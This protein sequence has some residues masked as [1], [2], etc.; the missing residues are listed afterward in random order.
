MNHTKWIGTG[1]LLGLVAFYALSVWQAALRPA[2]IAHAVALGILAVCGAA[3]LAP[4]WIAPSRAPRANKIA[5]TGAG[6]AVTFLLCLG[7]GL[8]S[9]R[10][11]A[12]RAAEAAKDSPYCIQVADNW[13]GSYEP[14]RAWL[15]LSGLTMWSLS[16]VLHHAILV[17]GDDSGPKFLHWSYRQQEFVAGATTW[18]PGEFD[19]AVTCT[20]QRDFTSRLPIAFP[21]R[22]NSRYV[23]LSAQEAFRIPDAYQPRWSGGQ[24]R[25]LRLLTAA[26]DFQPLNTS[27]SRLTSWDYD[28]NSVSVEWNPDWLLS[29]MSSIDGRAVDQ[30]TEFGLRKTLIVFHGRDGKD[31]ESHRYTLDTGWSDS[32]GTTLIQCSPATA[33]LPKSCQH[34]FLKNGRHYYFRQRPEDVPRWREMQQRLLD[35]FASFEAN[36]RAT[37]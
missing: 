24:T 37:N 3:M 32:D 5:L 1:L 14:A 6:F 35:L 13:Q 30:G 31:Y 10:T 36:V 19:P 8:Q 15:D 11:V 16:R 12:E 2:W 25:T 34:R 33:K 29:L 21:K 26:P 23:R 9:S 17:V 27:W 4:R 20:P 22:S 7:A 18:R 28:S